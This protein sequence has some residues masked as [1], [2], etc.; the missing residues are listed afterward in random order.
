VIYLLL[1]ALVCV[2]LAW[3]NSDLIKRGRRIYHALNG[4]LHLVAAAVGWYYFSW[5]IGVAIL[6]MARV[7]FDV[8]LNLFR[9][10][11]IDYVSP[12]PKS[13]IDKLEKK[14][15][16]NNGIVPKLIYL[17]IVIALVTSNVQ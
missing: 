11:G 8:S 15:F 9:G 13:V 4:L 7:V 14:V 5:Q 3:L 2:Q 16:K 6:P 1:Y 10:L 17:I 12:S